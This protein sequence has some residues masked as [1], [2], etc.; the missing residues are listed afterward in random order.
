MDQRSR[1]ANIKRDRYLGLEQRNALS[2]ASA[3]N[4][5][6]LTLFVGAFVFVVVLAFLYDGYDESPWVVAGLASIASIVSFVLFREIVLR[7]SRQRE[8]AARRLAHHLSAARKN[9]RDREEEVKLTLE[10]NEK[11][12]REIRSKSDAAKVLGNLVEAHKEVY[13]LCDE[14]LQTVSREIPRARAGSPRIP[15]MR[16]GSVTAAKR[17][18]YHML[19][20]AELKSRSFTL[21]ARQTGSVKSTIGAAEEA[22]E[23][24]ERAKEAY[25]AEKALIDSCDLLLV[26]LASAKVRSF[27]QDAEEAEIAGDLR[28][29]LRGLSCALVEVTA[30]G[31]ILDD[32]AVLESKIR[33]EVE[34]VARLMEN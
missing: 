28:S 17:H 16:K 4:Y 21:E 26:F 25:P 2:W 29:A 34:R 10:R 15:A 23:A 6:F 11:L 1:S 3:A 14:Y 30:H 32:T 5:Y 8:L 19:R 22:L 9:A 33:S 31:P 18:R 20:W 13:D 27:L 12:L 24:V 7:R